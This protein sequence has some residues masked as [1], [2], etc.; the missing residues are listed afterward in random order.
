MHCKYGASLRDL[1]LFHDAPTRY[2]RLVEIELTKLSPQNLQH[3]LNNTA[4][5]TDDAHLLVSTGP[6]Y[7]DRT[8]AERKITSDYVLERIGV[9]VFG[10]SIREVKRLCKTSQIE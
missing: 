10:G 4:D 7:G 5:P 9:R 6:S 2:D 3:L 1:F 8:I